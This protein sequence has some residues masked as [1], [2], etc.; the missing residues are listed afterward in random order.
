MT[1]DEFFAGWNS[2]PAAPQSFDD[3]RPWRHYQE[4]G[5][6]LM[7]ELDRRLRE[8]DER[9][10]ATLLARTSELAAR[11][12]TAPAAAPAAPTPVR[13]SGYLCPEC[14]ST[15][16]RYHDNACSKFD[17]RS[18]TDAGMGLAGRGE[19]SDMTADEFKEELRD[20][21]AANVAKRNQ[22]LR[23]AGL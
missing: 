22:R 1:H 13:A 11:L 15:N 12:G 20:I 6:R 14:S 9:E 5:H 17:P 2:L 23:E 7:G 3:L 19:R 8:S 10:L 4:L 18:E 21:R 16:A